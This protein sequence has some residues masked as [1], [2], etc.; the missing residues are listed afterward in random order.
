LA[1]ANDFV[2]R[3]V[4]PVKPNGSLNDRNIKRV[5]YCLAQSS[6][7]SEVLYSQEQTWN[8][9]NPAPTF[10]STASCP[11]GAWGGSR[12]L[13]R[14]VVNRENNEGVFSF[15][16]LPAAQTT[17]ELTK[18]RAVQVKLWVD[19]N[20]GKRPAATRLASGV[21]LRNQNR[22]PIASCTAT[23]AG[24]NQV[25]LNGSASEDPEGRAIREY[26]WFVGGADTG[27]KGVVARWTATA[28]GT[29]TFRLRVRDVGGLFGEANC[30]LPVVVP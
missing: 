11:D 30:D 10:P 19:V 22:Q 18:V 23:W 21:F 8:A 25:V 26:R 15:T 16:P 17:D 27:L 3:T 9:P 20:P 28:P 7:N 2:F 13:A 12:E 14:D 6:G 29:Y 24:N 4:D 5:R 1:Q